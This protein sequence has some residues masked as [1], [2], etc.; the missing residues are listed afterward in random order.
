MGVVQGVTLGVALLGAALGVINTFWALWRDRVRLRLVPVWERGLVVLDDGQS[1]S[2]QTE[3]E[4]GLESN[5]DGRIGLRVINR[6]LVDVTIRS[7]GFTD[8]GVLVRTFR[9]ARVRRRPILGDADGRVQL[10]CRLG[11]RESITVWC[12]DVGD[13]L[14]AKLAGVTRAYVSTDCGLTVYRTTPM[15]RRL[16]RE[17]RRLRQRSR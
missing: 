2:V 9:R 8:A 3:F 17:A 10:P 1:M 5:P 12:A 4:A 14:D 11:A 7:V 6:G 15:L 13:Q 16:A